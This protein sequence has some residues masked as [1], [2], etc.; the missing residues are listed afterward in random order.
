MIRLCFRLSFERFSVLASLRADC[1]HHSPKLALTLPCVGMAFVDTLCTGPRLRALLHNPVAQRGLADTTGAAVAR[2]LA[3][4]ECSLLR[5]M[6]FER[7]SSRQIWLG[8]RALIASRQMCSNRLRFQRT[9]ARLP[10]LYTL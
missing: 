2:L 3:A 1:P 10:V 7:S 5:T 9:N 8:A 6:K 4:V